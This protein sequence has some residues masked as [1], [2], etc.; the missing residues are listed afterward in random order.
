MSAAA[1]VVDLTG[2]PSSPP[3]YLSHGNRTPYVDRTTEQPKNP[4]IDKDAGAPPEDG[5]LHRAV[6]PTNTNPQKQRKRKKSQQDPVITKR[7]NM[8]SG[9]KR[10]RRGDEPGEFSRGNSPSSGSCYRETSST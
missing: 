7:E 5:E 10:R 8:E 2:L 3:V 1:E 4:A 6:K 9:D